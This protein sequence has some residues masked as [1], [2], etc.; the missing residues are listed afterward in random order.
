MAV[1]PRAHPADAELVRK[2]RRLHGVVNR[3]VNTPPQRPFVE[4]IVPGSPLD[5]ETGAPLDEFG[6]VVCTSAVLEEAL[7]IQSEELSGR[8]D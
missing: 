4:R 2:Q 3:V 1:D 6:N 7:R 5:V 8:D